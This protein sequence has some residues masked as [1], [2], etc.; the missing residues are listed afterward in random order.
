M[1]AYSLDLRQRI[2]AAVDAAE[3][4]L[5]EIAQLFQVSVSC[6][7]RLLQRR[8]ACGSLA[9]KPH[10]G[11][12]Q[13][14]L[15]EHDEQRLLDLLQQQPDATLTELRDRLGV[16]C[17][18]MT[19]ARAL[20]RHH[21]TRKKKNPYADKRD[22]PEVQTKRR[23]FQKKVA[24]VDP[25]HLVFVD[26]MGAT[27]KM[28]RTYGRAPQGERVYQAVP[29]Q[30]QSVTFLAG[31]RLAGVTAPFAFA[32]AVDGPTFGAY[33]E[34]VLVPQLQRGDVV[35]WDNLQPHKG[36]QALAAVEGAGATVVPAPPWSPDMIPIE[37]MFSKVKEGLR[38]LAARTTETVYAALRVTLDGVCRNDILGWF[39]DCGLCANHA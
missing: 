7:T 28:T 35:I 22:T 21:I 27:T 16:P 11:G 36:K 20:S 4:T 1:R 34:E 19:I 30:W 6:I 24:E 12:P 33:V 13:S 5:A 3:G 14:K 8:R 2:V 39:Q 18:I 38:S 17:S 15:T 32:G 23:A 26:E 29:G 10:A 9:P 37:E 25:E 31:L